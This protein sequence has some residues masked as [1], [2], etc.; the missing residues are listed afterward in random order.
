MSSVSLFKR[1][2]RAADFKRGVQVL[3]VAAELYVGFWQLGLCGASNH[4]SDSKLLA[5]K[6][7]RAVNSTLQ[8]AF[9]TSTVMFASEDDH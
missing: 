2:V 1:A 3:P 5:C 8:A 4:L 6:Y 9:D 7:S